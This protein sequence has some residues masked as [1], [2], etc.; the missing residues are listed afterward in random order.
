M[1]FPQNSD[2]WMLECILDQ[3]L[4]PK[5]AKNA[6][7][8]KIHN[9]RIR[10]LGGW[11]HQKR[12]CDHDH[13][14]DHE[15]RNIPQRNLEAHHKGDEKWWISFEKLWHIWRGGD[16]GMGPGWEIACRWLCRSSQLLSSLAPVTTSIPLSSFSMSFSSLDKSLPS[17]STTL[18]SSLSPQRIPEWL[19]KGEKTPHRLMIN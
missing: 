19:L 2:C 6:K 15:L 8:A 13:D 7:Y 10:M 4:F 14:H 1:L 9:I 5:N 12:S 3:P 17:P 18:S 11:A 16:G